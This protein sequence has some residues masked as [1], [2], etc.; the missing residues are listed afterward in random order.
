MTSGS[1]HPALK[2][3]GF[4]ASIA[5]R[6]DLANHLLSGGLDFLWRR[7]A[8]RRISEQ[9]PRRILDLA[10]GSGDLA[11]VLRKMCPEAAVIGADFCLPMLCVAREKGVGTLIGAD[12]LRLPFAPDSFDAA[13]VAFGL[14][15]M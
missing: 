5:S 9:R 7:I 14:R 6:Y 11:L 3:R 13:T 4:F 10:T 1:L 15:N 2:I 12:A 8:A